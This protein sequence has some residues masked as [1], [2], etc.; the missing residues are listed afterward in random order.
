VRFYT[1]ELPT[2]IAQR[3]VE[4]IGADL[5]D[6]IAH[7]RARGSSD[8]RIWLSILSRMARG[9]AADLAWRW[10]VRPVKGDFV[11]PFVAI[12]AVALGVAAIAFVA[13]S[14]AILLVSIGL[15][16]ADIL[17]VFAI[18]VRNAQQRDFLIP[19]VAVLAVALG[20]AALG[21]TAIV[22]GERG[23]APG[24]VLLGIVVIT[25]V[26]VGAFALGA[27]TTERSSR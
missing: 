6:H 20:V 15:I 12:L 21:V 24:L 16:V 11:K 27:R 22:V 23:D 3:R 17:G 13:D 1:R 2:P 4:E 5:A 26:I 18:G 25:S 9:M 14:P 10:H 8:P 7:E 19:F